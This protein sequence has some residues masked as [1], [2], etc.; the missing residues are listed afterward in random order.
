MAVSLFNRR[1]KNSEGLNETKME[2]TEL[3][4]AAL[5]RK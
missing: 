5:V 2:I 4:S 3:N 1:I